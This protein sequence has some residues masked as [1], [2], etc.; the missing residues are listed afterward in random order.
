MAATMGRDEVEHK[1]TAA[2]AWLV[3]DKPFLGAL[4]LRLPLIEAS[5][6][7]CPTTATDA[8][9]F[10]Y[11]RAYIESLSLEQTK[12]ILAHEALHCAL[13]HFARRLHR[14][15]RRWDIA[16]DYAINP[17]LM[18]DGLEPPPRALMRAAFQDMTAEEIY[19]YIKDTD[20]DETLDQHLYDEADEPQQADGRGS[21][22][23][24]GGG[25]AG[26]GN[27]HQPP[28]GAGGGSPPE[29][30]RGDSGAAQAQHHRGAEPPAPLH[31][32]ERDALA[33]QWQQ[34][35]AG[36]AQQ[37][38]RAG[39]LGG[40]LARL[41]ERLLQAQLPWRALLA[42]YMTSATRTDYSFV[43]PSRRDGAAILPSLHSKHIDVVVVIDTSG[44]IN[45]EEM[46]EFVTELN[47]IKGAVHAR[48]TLH[49]CDA[50][51]APDGP[52]TY[53]PWEQLRLPPTLPGGGGTN[54]TP[55]FEWAE[56]LDRQ[57]DLLLY[58]TDANGEFPRSAPTFPVLWLVKGKQKVPW[59]QRL[60]LN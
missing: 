21:H 3:I 56:R 47:G 22:G 13:S 17:L 29:R 50:R 48:I 32:A 2:R 44:S 41:V 15:K 27:Q 5:P 34:R 55:A 4:V 33:S 7:W 51:L 19:P 58:F 39:K 25:A 20:S 30:G 26:D 1:L 31:P 38:L 16:C 42:R 14:V 43:R 52:W 18:A 36:A 60:Q 54:F 10:Y 23:N 46:R 9:A 8:R 57:P 24:H 53:E 40:S 35:L 59:G 12:F 6:R 11:N 37:A 28:P 49:T 45:A